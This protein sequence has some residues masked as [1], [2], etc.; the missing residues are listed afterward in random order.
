MSGTNPVYGKDMY[1]SDGT[2][3]S[4]EQKLA[5]IDQNLRNVE[6]SASNLQAKTK[7]LNVTTKKQRDSIQNSAI[8]A[9]KLATEQRKLKESYTNTAVE[10]KKIQ[11]I[12]KKQN[13]IQKLELQLS[14]SAIGSYDRVS[15]Q[16]SLL[17]IKL[18]AMSKAQREN[19]VAGRA[20]VAQSKELYAE[21]NRLQKQTGKNQLNVGNYGAAAKQAAGQLLGFAS[22]VGAAILVIRKISQTVKESIQT[23][24]DFEKQTSKV[25]A[26]SGAAGDEMNMLIA[27]AQRLGESTEKTASQVAQL[28]LELAKLGFNP[29]Q[30]SDATGSILDLST[31]I[32]ADL[33][34]SATVV[35]QTLRAF[36]LEASETQRVTDVMASSFSKSSL[37]INKFQSAMST[38]APVAKT[39]GFSLEETVALLAQLTDAGFDASSSGTAL[40]NILLN[41]AD[42]NGKLAKALGGSVSNADELLTG[43][44]KLRESGVDLNTTLE[45]TD[46]RSVA[47]FNRFLDATDKT[48]KLTKELNNAAGEGSRMAAIMRDNL[49]GDIDKAKSA[50]Q[51]LYI[52]LGKRLNPSLRAG[53]QAVTSFVDRLSKYVA[54]QPSDEMRREQAELNLLVRAATSANNTQESRNRLITELQTKYPDFLSNLDKEKVTNEELRDRLAEVNAEYKKK[55]EQ[56]VRQELIV[57]NQEKIKELQIDELELIKKLETARKDLSYYEGRALSAAEI[58]AFVSVTSRVNGYTSA[59]ERNRRKQNQLF[60][61]I[62]ADL[63]LYGNLHDTTEEN[64]EV[65]DDNTDSTKE[66]DKVVK[67][68]SNTLKGLREELARLKEEKE[69][70]DVSDTKSLANKRREIDALDKLIQAYEALGE[71]IKIEDVKIEGIDDFETLVVSDES[72]KVF[73]E[74]RKERLKDITETQRALKDL[75]QMHVDSLLGIWLKYS[76]KKKAVQENMNADEIA[77]MLENNAKIEEATKT[78]TE[79]AIEQLQYLYDQ[80]VEFAN[81]ALE[82]AQQEVD[83]AQTALE[84]EIANREA[85]F[86][87]SVATRQKELADA[88]KTQDKANAEKAKAVKQQQTL[89][90]IT[91][92]SSLITASANIWSSMSSIPIVGP[93]LALAA[94]ALMWGSF[95]YSKVK[96]KQSA[97]SYGEGGTFDIFGGTHESG[98]DTSLGIHGGRERKVEKGEKV[99][100]IKAKAVKH[101]GSKNLDEVIKSINKKEFNSNFDKSIIKPSELP[102][103]MLINAGYDS[104]DLKPLEKDVKKIREQGD[105]KHFTDHKGRKVIKYKSLT[106]IYNVQ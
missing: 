28:Q 81:M 19:T 27:Q 89:D 32:D 71:A 6:A 102:D 77:L 78:A 95:A 91:Q 69:L 72:N 94:I 54:L 104:P 13:Q 90:S 33:G 57:R 14:K 86:A 74:L 80:K 59:L 24:T 62:E 73:D 84:L 18:N 37:D 98:H 44:D 23:W 31:A 83:F 65:T 55:I 26:I 45:L 61:E 67:D 20:M 3:E 88:K 85:G 48:R 10:I 52:N 76:A 7:N 46:K 12:R 50:T 34:Q 64:T 8:Q 1:V 53:V 39:F 105:T 82:K 63:E 58:D 2:L 29:K 47:A 35:G 51:G 68:Y 17:K 36:N 56:L 30:I 40:R 93:L 92:A 41:L 97:E 99:S 5:S 101:Y 100:I 75:E 43:L 4:L 15:A 9:N 11:A 21:M 49:A 79:M 16:Y 38:V 87:N 22:G 60:K 42:G 25:Q 66:G 106:R 70:I 96:A 103:S